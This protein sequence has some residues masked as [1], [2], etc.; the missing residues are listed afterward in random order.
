VKKRKVKLKTKI[1]RWWKKL[2]RKIKKAFGQ[3]PKR[4]P[5]K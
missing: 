5:K 1:K 3:N 4:K 2:C